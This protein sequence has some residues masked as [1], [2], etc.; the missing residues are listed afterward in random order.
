MCAR[1]FLLIVFF[2]TV[3]AVAGAFAIFQFG[4]DVL[5]EQATPRGGFEPPPES[6]PDYTQVSSWIAS[7]EVPQNAANWLPRGQ[8]RPPQL[9][10]DAAIFYV[11]PTTYLRRDRWNA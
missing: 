9:A 8:L 1:R 4:Q 5:L 3:L 2:L 7:P 10:G 11:H 6:G